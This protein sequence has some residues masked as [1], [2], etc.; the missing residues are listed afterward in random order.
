[1]LE[2]Q[3]QDASSPSTKIPLLPLDLSQ[4]KLP[5]TLYWA[6]IVLTSCLLPIVGYFALHYATSLSL[7]IIL[8]IFLSIMGGVSLL[9]FLIRAWALWRTNSDCRPLGSNNRWAFDYFFWNFVFMFCVLT[10]LI[11]S[12]ITT[13]NLQIVSLPLSILILWVSAQMTIAEILLALQI[14]VPFRMS[15]LQKSDTLRPGVY[16][17]VEDVVA[18]DGKQGRAWRQAW[19]DRYISSPIFKQF[20]SQIERIWAVTGLSVVAIIW[21]VVFG[22]E[23]HEIGY[24]LGWALPFAWGAGMALIT[25]VLAK[26]MLRQEKIVELDQ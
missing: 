3:P 12:G 25:T 7:T 10:A 19:N 4:H 14:K 5:I 20:L 21:G 13:E 6:P 22:L 1:M 16:V 26:R 9:A 24:A 2:Y 15:S 17:I 18:V 23:N 8:S 11:T